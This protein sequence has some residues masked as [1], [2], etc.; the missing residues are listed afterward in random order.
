MK[1]GRYQYLEKIGEGGM[2]TVYR[3]IQ[4]S[5]DREVAI[6]VLDASLS[7]NP[8]VIK[9]FKRESLIIA[10]LNHPNIIHVIDKGTTSKGRPVFVMEFVEGHNLADAIAQQLYDFNERVDIVVQVCKGLAYAHKLDVIHRDIKPANVLVDKEGHARL[11]DF[12]IASFFKKDALDDGDASLVMGSEAYMAPEQSDSAGK[13]SRQSDI[14][15]LGVLIFELLIGHLPSADAPKVLAAHPQIPN[16]LAQLIVSCMAHSPQ[17]RPKSVDELVTKL[18][19]AMGGQHINQAQAHRA[20]QGMQAMSAKFSLLDVLREDKLGATYLYEDKGSHQLIVIKKQ[21]NLGRGLR[22]AKLLASLQHPH[23]VNVLGSSETDGS[24]I[25]VMEYLAGGALQDRLLE[26]M[27]LERFVPMALGVARG[28]AFAHSNN[29]IH[30]N[31]RPSNVMFNADMQVKLSDFGFD[32]HERLQQQERDWYRDGRAKLDTFTDIYAMGAVFY[33]ALTSFAPTFKEG[34]LVKS[35][36]FVEQPEDLQVLVERML[37]AEIERRPQ[38][39]E[40]VVSE[41]VG[42]LEQD[43]TEIKTQILEPEQQLDEPKAASKGRLAPVLV[44]ITLLASLGLNA[45]LLERHHQ[46]F[47]GLYVQAMAWM[48]GIS[49]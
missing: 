12:G 25:V 2:A 35:K 17:I 13:A 26:P 34:R 42:L 43:K 32:E 22:E 24:F 16:E 20:Q 33:H 40:A 47:S 21:Q 14:Y 31:L 28:I 30:A 23:W 15:S 6:K 48:A 1:E 46:A 45:Y 37:S 38:S 8:S 5:L 49:L 36:Y 11:L 29:I 7:D 27:P 4:R 44:Q 9:R 3:G 18:L 19:M 10:R 41:L 39:A